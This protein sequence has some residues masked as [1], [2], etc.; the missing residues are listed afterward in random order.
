M[1]VAVSLLAKTDGSH[2]LWYR[3]ILSLYLYDLYELMFVGLHLETLQ[4]HGILRLCAKNLKE[5]DVCLSKMF[6]K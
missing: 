2:K 3:D 4:Q 5:H 1:I 6:C